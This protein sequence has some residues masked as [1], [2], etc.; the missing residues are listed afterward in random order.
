M[1]T[2]KQYMQM[3][4]IQE[5]FADDQNKINKELITL[6]NLG[7]L[8]KIEADKKMLELAQ[9][10]NE[11][12]ELIKT[13]KIDGVEYGFIPNLNN[14]TVGE[15]VDL[16]TYQSRKDSLHKLMAI[17]YRPIV[18]KLGDTYNIEPYDGTEKTE[19]LMLDTDVRIFNSAMVFF[20]TLSKKLL[21]GLDT[22]I[23]NQTK[24][25]KKTQNQTQK[26]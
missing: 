13:F 23:Q 10:I 20:Y 6:F 7:Q 14:I 24:I 8:T 2:L 11:E 17:L 26:N 4:Q 22:Y 18:N 9:Y 3:L 12:N 21:E 19:K 15:W 16:D 1:V 25:L 5:T